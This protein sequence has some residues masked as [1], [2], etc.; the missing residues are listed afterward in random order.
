MILPLVDKAKRSSRARDTKIYIKCR[1]ASVRTRI[2]YDFSKTFLLKN[3]GFRVIKKKGKMVSLDFFVGE[4][5]FW[6]CKK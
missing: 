5:M 3:K 2:S 4:Q 1:K 6:S